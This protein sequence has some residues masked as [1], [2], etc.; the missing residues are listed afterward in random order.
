MLSSPKINSILQRKVEYKLTNFIYPNLLTTLPLLIFAASILFFKFYGH[1]SKAYLTLWFMALLVLVVC[2]GVL[3]SWFQR[4]KYARKWDHLYLRLLVTNAG[5]IG[6]LWGMVGVMF[7]PED[8][9]GQSY[10]IFTLAFVAA[11][12]LV[13]LTGSYLAGVAYTTGILIP[14]AATVFF[15]LA[16]KSQYEI[17]FNTALG[18]VC[19]WVFLLAVNYYGS[20]LYAEN[21]TQRII[22]KSLADDLTDASEELEKL[23]AISCVEDEKLSLSARPKT[24]TQKTIRQYVDTLTGGD[25][26][27]ILE[28]KFIQS[29]AYARRHHQGLAVFSIEIMNLDDVK[30]TLGEDMGNLF[31]KAVAIRLQHCKRETDILAQSNDNTFT[32]IISEVL[33]GNEITIVTNRIFRKFAEDILINSGKFKINANIGISLFPLDGEDLAELINKSKIALLN[34]SSENDPSKP[35]FQ[36]YDNEK[37]SLNTSITPDL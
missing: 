34:L 9:V 26:Q 25:T 8:G 10:L 13:Y 16:L 3:A 12:G 6:V 27:E 31:L 14:L 18:I 7:M 20:K 35:H 37:S 32:L 24:V 1:A 23:N 29:R 5:V 30:A 15:S 11:G 22:N 21:F 4:V 33:L 19:Y 17:Y 2:Q 28:V 36:I